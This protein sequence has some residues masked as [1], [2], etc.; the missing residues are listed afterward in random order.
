MEER[1]LPCDRTPRPN[2]SLDQRKT[3]VRTAIAALS[4]ALAAG[5]AK[6]I[7]SRATGS[8]AFRGW[9][10]G[11]NARVS[12]ACAFRMIMVSGSALAKQ[13]IARAEQLAGRTVD[14]QALAQGIHAHA[15]GNG[16]LVWHKGH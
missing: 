11:E 8:V 5:T 4:A 13:A 2:Q 15:D 7:V 16:N 1:D 14:R 3:E 12:D 9:E 10:E 6:A